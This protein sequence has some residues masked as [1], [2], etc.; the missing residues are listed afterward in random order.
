MRQ[1][2]HEANRRSD[3]GGPDSEGGGNTSN[4]VAGLPSGSPSM[5]Q[6]VI[7]LP[8]GCG[9]P[10]RQVAGLT[11]IERLF[12]QVCAAGVDDIV[13]LAAARLSVPAP[14]QRVS[15][16]V[17]VLPSQGDEAWAMLAE[18]S[19]ELADRF[20]VVA[21]DLVVD[22]R[23]LDWL[24]E[25]DSN[26]LLQRTPASAPEL[27]GSLNRAGVRS[28]AGGDDIHTTR[29]A[30]TSFPT[31][32]ARQRGEVPIHLL[33][34]RD[35]KD[36]AHA[37]SVLLDHVDKRT[38]DL[39]AVL[40][41]PPFENFLV[42]MLAPTAITPNQVTVVTTIIAFF[43]VWLFANGWLLT[44]VLL[45]IVVE[46]LDGVD[47]KLARI[48][49]MTSRIGELEHVLD[50]FYENGW[51]LALGYHLAASGSAWA[52]NA[53]LALVVFDFSDNLAYLV[54]ARRGGGNLDE[55]SAFWGRFRLIAGRRNIYVWMMLPGV[56]A[57]AAAVAYAAVVAW[58]AFT[59]ILHWAMALTG[60]RTSR[61]HAADKMPCPEEIACASE[62]TRTPSSPA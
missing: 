53:A 18:A 34:V 46:V 12:R 32:W 55:A 45:A 25:R 59:A 11:L 61:P 38:K 10:L 7:V 62:E 47:G 52:W 13:V 33:H 15:A 44:A 48:K 27:L 39:P 3:G 17:R 41:D 19:A 6:V 23:L 28:A 60:K 30:V 36:A 40:F 1:E 21:G 31:Y 58:S 14:S 2:H 16:P 56:L 37:E 49:L 24:T 26:V 50:F 9:D 57:G 8:R 20:L 29:V 42:R 22:Q 43:G 51:Y 4:R 54:F 5:R 35:R